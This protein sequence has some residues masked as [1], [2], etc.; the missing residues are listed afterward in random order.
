MKLII[1]A[2]FYIF[3]LF[4][5]VI[6]FILFPLLWLKF[7]AFKLENLKVETCL[8]LNKLYEQDILKPE[9]YL[10]K[11]RIFKGFFFYH[12]DTKKVILNS[13]SIGKKGSATIAISNRTDADI[14][15]PLFCDL[16]VYKIINDHLY[17]NFNKGKITYLS[18]MISLIPKSKEK[19]GQEENPAIDLTISFNRKLEIVRTSKEYYDFSEM[20]GHQISESITYKPL[21]LKEELFL[22]LIEEQMKNPDAYALL[23]E[24]HTPSAYDF[25]SDDFKNRL[26]IISMICI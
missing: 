3:K 19:Y 14:L 2:I 13:A 12:K 22:I 1:D 8:I 5:N 6:Y 15:E 9:D 11:Y 17:L 26:L 24:F 21:P 7:R 10:I 18:W 16:L 23:P 25:Q 20:H 4:Y